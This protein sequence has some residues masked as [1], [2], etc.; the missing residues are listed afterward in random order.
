MTGSEEHGSS[1]FDPTVVNPN[2]NCLPDRYEVL[3]ILGSGGMGRVLLARD[4]VLGREVAVKLL[5][6][7]FATDETYGQRFLAEARVAASLNHPGIV[8]IYEFGRTGTCAYLV[9]EYVDGCS[10]RAM[11]SEY[12]PYGEGR[13]CELAAVAC[14]ALGAAHAQGIVH[15]D[16]KPDN[17]MLTQSG[18]FK[19]VDLGLAKC[20]RSD[21]SLT[22]SGLSIGTPHFISPEQVLG[23]RDI[24]HRTD[25]YSL[26]ASLYCLAT[27]QV[28]FGGSSSAHVM[29]RHLNDPVPDPR[30][31]APDLS[32]AFCGVVYRAMAKDPA[33]RYQDTAA[34]QAELMDVC[35]AAA[36][37]PDHVPESARGP[38]ACDPADMP[39]IESALAHAIGPLARVLVERAR[40]QA[41]SR[42]AL[43]HTLADHITDEDA[44]RRFLRECGVEVGSDVSPRVSSSSTLVSRR[45]NAIDA[46]TLDTVTTKLTDQI[47]P[48]A[49]IVVKREIAAGGDA[50]ELVQRLAAQIPDAKARGAF[51]AAVAPLG[52]AAA[53]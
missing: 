33:A 6:D 3:K 11:I 52:L 18:Q 49:R 36:G 31:H 16:V 20:L 38:G 32:D 21:S 26:G 51:L 10:L 25:I 9:M 5:V 39:A 45:A 24:D 17:M 50:R 40:R 27:G 29:A 8:Q 34:L 47:G 13:A 15:R 28:P 12:G 42:S 14:E 37:T 1:P 43:L 23:A 48:V 35:G 46:A 19:L 41:P 30:Q 2:Q 53:E 22:Q 7:R 44:R 4:R